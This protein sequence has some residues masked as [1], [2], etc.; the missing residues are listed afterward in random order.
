[1]AAKND[2]KL[3]GTSNWCQNNRNGYW[4]IYSWCISTNSSHWSQLCSHFRIAYRRYARCP[5][6]LRVN[7]VLYL[8]SLWVL[9]TTLSREAK[10]LNWSVLAPSGRL[11]CSSKTVTA[12]VRDEESSSSKNCWLSLTVLVFCVHIQYFST[13]PWWPGTK[14][15]KTEASQL[16][17][18]SYQV[19]Q[20]SF[21]ALLQ[22]WWSRIAEILKILERLE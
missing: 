7:L 12:S 10:W 14:N 8:R 20:L 6:L 11:C 5:Q 19:W 16:S 4:W 21:L 3:C 22:T 13:W 15:K 17:C 2:P 18:H 1:M 9:Y